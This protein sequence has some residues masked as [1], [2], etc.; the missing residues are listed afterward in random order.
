[1]QVTAG[2]NSGSAVLDILVDVVSQHGFQLIRVRPAADASVA[3]QVPRSRV[4][5]H[6]PGR[7]ARTPTADIAGLIEAFA[8]LQMEHPQWG[9]ELEDLTYDLCML[10]IVDET[11]PCKRPSPSLGDG[12][13]TV[14]PALRQRPTANAL[15]KPPFARRRTRQ[16]LQ[17]MTRKRRQMLGELYR[18]D[19][20]ARASA[21]RLAFHEFLVSNISDPE[22]NP[23]VARPPPVSSGQESVPS[24]LRRHRAE[25]RF[26]HFAQQRRVRAGIRN[27][28]DMH[29][30]PYDDNSQEAPIPLSPTVVPG[31]ANFAPVSDRHIPS[32]PC[33]PYNAYEWCST[34]VIAPRFDLGQAP[35]ASWPAQ[36]PLFWQ[37][38]VPTNV[39]NPHSAPPVAP[40]VNNNPVIPV[41]PP[42]NN[43]PVRPGRAGILRRVWLLATRWWG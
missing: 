22:P 42:A 33:P 12:P 25:S 15:V 11:T 32:Q 9:P 24:R 4:I 5:S 3:S 28:G 19:C 27:E 10:T 37:A 35:P 26:Q 16:Q 39:L 34:Q 30:P 2:Y 13:S 41:A 17:E 23:L 6:Q 14:A 21:S 40:V 38:A 43:N 31:Y 1:M 29:P 7:T 8:D 20:E 36:G 18:Q